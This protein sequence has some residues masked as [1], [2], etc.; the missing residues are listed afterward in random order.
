MLHKVKHYYLPGFSRSG[1]QVGYLLEEYGDAFLWVLWKN[2]P[3]VSYLGPIW[4][5]WENDIT[6]LGHAEKSRLESVYT[7]LAE[8]RNFLHT[9]PLYDKTLWYAQLVEH[10][11]PVIRFCKDGSA[12]EEKIQQNTNA[13]L[14]RRHIKEK[15]CP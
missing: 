2:T 7:T 11:Q 3:P 15:L 12:A 10:D 1:N 4:I 6:V 13:L 9:L 8:V 5:Y 14:T